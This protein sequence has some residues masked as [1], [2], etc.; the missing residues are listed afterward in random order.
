MLVL[1]FSFVSASGFPGSTHCRLQ[2]R[3]YTELISE[4][5]RSFL[6]EINTVAEYMNTDRLATAVEQLAYTP[7][8][9]QG[10]RGG[11]VALKDGL[12]GQY[13]KRRNLRMFMKR[14]YGKSRKRALDQESLEWRV[15]S[16][17]D[18]CE[19][20]GGGLCFHRR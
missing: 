19:C 1:L 10:P 17:A 15:C 6:S 18:V 20:V 9:A 2:L 16:E 8:L 13:F 11:N 4:L 12:Q 14:T 7:Y 3:K 5:L